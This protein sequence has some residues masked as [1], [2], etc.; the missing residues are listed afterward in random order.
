MNNSTLAESLKAN[1]GKYTISVVIFIII[2]LVVYKIINVLLNNP[3]TNAAGK[4]I[5]DSLLML[6]DFTKGCCKQSTCS[7][8]AKDTCNASC[9]CGWGNNKCESTTGIKTGKGGV[10]TTECPLGL[11][12]FIGGIAWVV[13]NVGGVIYGVFR[14]KPRTA[15]D[16]LA[17]KINRPVDELKLELRKE[18]DIELAKLENKDSD[19]EYK[20]YSPDDKELA[21]KVM[22][23]DVYSRTILDPLK[24]SG[25]DT[26]KAHNDATN[27]ALENAKRGSKNADDIE[28]E[29]TEEIEREVPDSIPHEI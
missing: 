22:V 19:S 26:W 17:E 8:T 14:S 5:N 21:N 29:V 7:A 6:S 28:R 20:N 13:F 11:G 12:L 3:I 16:D 24:K 2:A 15:I 23:K 4:I 25:G 9:G 18:I 10:L 1:W 27:A